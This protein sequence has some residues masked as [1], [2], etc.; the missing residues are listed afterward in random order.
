MQ[1]A[2]GLILVH[3]NMSQEDVK[4]METCEA[5]Q[6]TNEAQQKGLGFSISLE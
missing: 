4:A 6:Y 2:N 3:I 5:D 1:D